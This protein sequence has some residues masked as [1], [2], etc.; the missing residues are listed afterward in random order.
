MQDVPPGEAQPERQGTSGEEGD[1]PS[2]GSGGGQ[3]AGEGGDDAVSGETEP[4]DE[5]TDEEETDDEGTGDEG[6]G[7][8][9]T[10]DAPPGEEA[11]GGSG[12]GGT[13]GGGD[14]GA[15]G[16]GTNGFSELEPG[17]VAL[18]EVAGDAF[19][20]ELAAMLVDLQG[21]DAKGIVINVSRPHVTLAEELGEHGVAVEDLYFIDCISKLLRAESTDEAQVLFLDGPTMLEMIAMGVDHFLDDVGPDGFVVF[22]SYGALIT[23]NNYELVYEFTNFLANKLR[24]RKIRGFLVIVQDQLPDTIHGSLAQLCDRVV[25]WRNGDGPRGGD[26]P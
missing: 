15:G 21:G 25:P 23:Y 3:P 1:A 12:G 18:V 2:G 5:G 22:D 24:I 9:G 6:T 16:G 13:G 10:D 8:E 4:V 17:D 26:A 20:E 7:D 14:G 19:V 11:G